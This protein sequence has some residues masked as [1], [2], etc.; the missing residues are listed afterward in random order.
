MRSLKKSLSFTGSFAML[1]AFILS[2]CGGAADKD[3][4]ANREAADS[5][6]KEVVL[7]ADQHN[8][9]YSFPTPFE[10]TTMLEKAKAGYIFDITN[11]PG[12]VT[13][14]G[15]EFKKALNLGVYSADLSYSTTYNRIDETN[16]F[17]AC[18]GKLADELGIAGVYDQTLLEK[19]KKYGN[20]K[21]T[22]VGII[23]R[24]LSSTNDFL[25]KNNRNQV[26]VL[27]VT[28]GFVEGMYLAIS[29]NE[30]ARDNRQIVTVILQ[31]KENFDKL[32]TILDAYQNDTEM[33]VIKNEVA[34][35]DKIFTGFDLKP[36]EKVPMQKAA[37]MTDLA[38]YVRLGFVK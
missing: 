8:L 36:G 20:N 32:L 21:D 28:G 19:V 37:E 14:Y 18:T 30:V 9:L 22:L 2:G 25:S 15:T 16:K 13:R 34:K 7:T 3:A 17:L 4:E 27:I 5:I 1:S 26:A 38:E 11:S 24:V 6:K 35:L 31:Q 12:N 23:T 29:L 10:V 33:S